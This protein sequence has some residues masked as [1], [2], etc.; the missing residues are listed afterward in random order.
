M[1]IQYE[2]KGIRY[3]Y[4]EGLLVSLLCLMTVARESREEQETETEEGRARGGNGRG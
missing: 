1:H 3:N 2:S 4:N